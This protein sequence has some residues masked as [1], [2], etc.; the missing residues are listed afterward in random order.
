MKQRL[1]TALP[2]VA[3]AVFVLLMLLVEKGWQP[4]YWGK[5]ACKL[6]VTAAILAVGCAAERLPLREVIFLRPLPKAGRLAAFVAAAFVGIWAGF[7]L[8]RGRFDLDGIRTS[9]MTKEHLTR[10]NCLFVFGYIIVVNSF[11]EE[12]LFRGYLVHAAA[13]AGHR[14]AGIVYSA[15]AFAVYH[16]GIMESWM[17]PA[18]LV[19]LVAGLAAVGA[20][21]TWVSLHFGS[22]KAGWLVHAGANVA[23]NSIGAWMIFT[24]G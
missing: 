13:R 5:S 22:L 15:L 2:F 19:L 8:L 16:I 18:L 24:G 3:G 9:L 11:L 12:A 23:I 4:G 10:Q 7:W 1:R 6:A 17:H 14:T 21:L 20:A